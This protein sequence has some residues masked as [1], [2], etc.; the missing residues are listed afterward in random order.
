MSTFAKVRHGFHD[1]FPQRRFPSY[2]GESAL[3][4][5]FFVSEAE[6]GSGSGLVQVDMQA[7]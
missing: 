7:T 5:S 2:D 4:G 6:S 3:A 1:P